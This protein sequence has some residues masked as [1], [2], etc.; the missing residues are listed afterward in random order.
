MLAHLLRLLGGSR[1]TDN[2]ARIWAVA[3]A[4][5]LP[6]ELGSRDSGGTRHGCGWQALGNI[7]DAQALRLSLARVVFSGGAHSGVLD[8]HSN[9][10]RPPVVVLC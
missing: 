8:M 6:A 2:V 4:A 9:G 3:G 1:C 7:D 10:F 5:M